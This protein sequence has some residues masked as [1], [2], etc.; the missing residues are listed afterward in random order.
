MEEQI[1]KPRG[2]KGS[3]AS[4]SSSSS[5]ANTT[6]NSNAGYDSNEGDNIKV[7]VRIRPPSKEI[8]D[9]END[10]CLEVS[11]RNSLMIATK[12]EPKQFS[13]DHVAGMETTQEEV[14]STV[15]KGIIEAYVGGFNGTIFAYGQTGSGKTFTMLG[16]PD[17]SDSFTHKLRGVIPRSFEYIFS[18][19]NHQREKVGDRVE[20]L[21]KCSFLEIYNESVYDLL[22][23]STAVLALRENIKKGVFVEGLAERTV[24]S[25]K[26]A[27]NVLQSGWL[28]RRVAS[29]S[30]NR[31]SSRSHAV[32]TFSLESKTRTGGVANIKESKLHL[33]D[34]A[35]SERQKDTQVAG[36]H[37]K[38]AGSINKSLST[39]G[40]V[41]MALVDIAHGKTR[42]IHYRDSK[43][44]FILRDSL[45]GNAKTYIIANVH[46]SSRCFGETL[47]TLNFA[48]KAKM[49]K[50][51]A[52][53]NEDISG[54]VSQLQAEIKKLKELLR[55]KNEATP[56]MSIMEKIEDATTGSPQ[57]T[58]NLAKPTSEDAVQW[59]QMMLSAISEREKAE[60]EKIVLQEKIDKLEELGNK[61]EKFLQST[62]MILKFRTQHIAK[63]ERKLK[64]EGV[65]VEE[66][67]SKDKQIKTLKEEIK[68]LQTSIE[69]HPDVKKYA[70][71]N[72]ELRTE[73]RRLKAHD[74]SN[75][76]FMKDMA[77]THRYTLQLERQLKEL[78]YTKGNVVTSSSPQNLDVPNC[79]EFE[80]VK[81]ELA[82]MQAKLDTSHKDLQ[83]ARQSVQQLT[84]EL[85]TKTDTFR[86]R[87]IE[88][89]SDLAAVR[90]AKNEV[91][92]TFEAFQ[93][94]T[95]VERTTMNSL[96][97]QTVKT[98]ASPRK[99]AS[100]LKF[101][102]P[103]TPLR[104]LTDKNSTPLKN[105]QLNRIRQNSANSIE[106]KEEKSTA[107][108]ER[109]PCLDDVTPP[110]LM[111]DDSMNDSENDQN[112]YPF[113]DLNNETR[114][115][116][117]IFIETLQDEIKQLQEQLTQSIDMVNQEQKKKIPLIEKVTKL[118]H[119]VKELEGILK[120]ERN[121]FSGKESELSNQLTSAKDKYKESYGNA[122]ILKSEVEDL[123]I[124]YSSVCT[125]LDN[126]KKAKDEDHIEA[127]RKCAAVESKFVKLQIDYY[128]LRAEMD[129]TV[130]SNNNLQCDYDQCKEELQFCHHKNDE[131][132]KLLSQ[133]KENVKE[134]ENR[135][136]AALEKLRYELETKITLTQEDKQEELM[137]AMETTN[138]LRDQ[139]HNVNKLSEEQ[140]AAVEKL[141]GELEKSKSEVVAQKWLNLSD[142]E[143]INNFMKNVQDLHVTI[144]EK[145]NLITSLQS[146]IE[147]LKQEH[148]NLRELFNEKKKKLERVSENLKFESEKLHGEK[149]DHEKAVSDL[150]TE[151]KLAQDQ[152][153]DLNVQL[154][155]HKQKALLLKGENV[156]KNKELSEKTQQLSA[157][158]ESLQLK[159]KTTS[160]TAAEGDHYVTCNEN[161]NENFNENL[162]QLSESWEAIKLD[163][164]TD[165]KQLN[166]KLKELQM[167][168][169]ERELLESR[170][171]MLELELEDSEIQKKEK[172]EKITNLELELKKLKEEKAKD[173]A[174]VQDTIRTKNMLTGEKAKL[175]KE[176]EASKISLVT[177]QEELNVNSEELEKTKALEQKYFEEN[178]VLQSRLAV[179]EEEKTRYEKL[180]KQ[181]QKNIDA[182]ELEKAKLVAHQNQN[183]RIEHLINIKKENFALR[184][185]NRRLISK[186]L[187]A[188]HHGP[189]EMK[190]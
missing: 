177:I 100:P 146:E 182:L 53:I 103:R 132:K 41:I 31:E 27:Y 91:E 109:S 8:Q 187:A 135:L 119:K 144:N 71:E 156:E 158:E 38:E 117:V 75:G 93:L 62:R 170:I 160:V 23:P 7:Y 155:E 106:N 180:S 94:K 143:A 114:D 49:I 79:D 6:I 56:D 99:F 130:E 11:S 134:V 147:D 189:T 40:N 172:L 72:V 73:I 128:N 152:V 165:N 169:S 67:D 15:G 66:E 5:K 131:L 88:L 162:T 125:Q 9:V 161:F 35:G 82:L 181:L 37:L 17:D 167:G 175:V 98:L 47:S 14:F 78:M 185:E 118:E 22:E 168:I 149:S 52:I 16:P 58:G 173:D 104:N 150:Q 184:E 74:P 36:V 89:Q 65:A 68:L 69:H 25:A 105:G 42:Y 122:A 120:T 127:G 57:Q 141:K 50:N 18:L 13:Y 55:E 183:Q 12:P 19:M 124:M 178:S 34:L 116:E 153:K 70:I 92:R 39:L 10:T 115:D 95:A 188:T 59:Q 171:S 3:A 29:T 81:M 133:E 44:T 60:K 87:E 4:T 139:L 154:D 77:E 136:E 28:N 45:G 46:P 140:E 129:S 174:L 83:E 121:S 86:N 113:W 97:M 102:T 157:L 63:L 126:A 80:K 112:G 43:L 61:K 159:Q 64:K 54:N 179:L 142:K 48:R 164:E 151:L 111:G 85:N 190:C 107:P 145:E 1:A 166:E 110:K 96:H 90:K 176:F 30:M 163:L 2:A 137:K 101:G 33:V 24:M 51:K 76:D 186:S 123:R 148:D 84:E 26:D 32:F 138:E 108:E 20:F 21:A